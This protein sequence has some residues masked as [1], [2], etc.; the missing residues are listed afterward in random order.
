MRIAPLVLLLFLLPAIDSEAGQLF[1]RGPFLE[2]CPCGPDSIRG[3]IRF[4][5]LQGFRGADFRDACRRHDDCYDRLGENRKCCDDRFLC[6]LLAD[7]ENSRQ[8]LRCRRK[9]RMT[10]WLVDRFGEGAFRSAQRLA[11]SKSGK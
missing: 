10:H 7:C 4:L 1:K 2:K 6:E 5:L 9:A 3:P 8:P 11:A